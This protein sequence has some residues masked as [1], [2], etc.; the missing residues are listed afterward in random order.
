MRIRFFTSI[1]FLTIIVTQSSGQAVPFLNYV[2][3]ARPAAM[4][5]AGYVLPS[6]FA[7]QRNISAIFQDALHPVGIAASYMLWQPQNANNKLV[8]IGGYS[9]FNNFGIAA[10]IHFNNMPDV[11][12][13]DDNGYVSGTFS[14]SEYALELGVGYKINS[15]LAAGGVVRYLGSDLGGIK[16]ASAVAFDVSFLYSNNSLS[17][18]LGL[19]NLGTKADYGNSKYSL[20]TRVNTGLAYHYVA[21]NRHVLTGVV[22]ANYQI[23]SGST[24]LGGGIG[25]EYVY[26]SLLALR[27]G[28]HF[29]NEKIGASYATVG[30]GLH[31]SGISIDFAYMIPP[32]NNVMSQT[33]LVSLK[34]AR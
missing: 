9:A 26:N 32:D 34:W 11:E 17:A 13:T 5:N 4:G 3:D 19:S 10:G 20:P 24:G 30:C 25:G 21:A 28:Y 2:A 16:K 23:V 14:P 18:G 12:Q 22:D 1:L 29:E 7:A 15:K 31:F 27:T 6:A 33:L 8:N